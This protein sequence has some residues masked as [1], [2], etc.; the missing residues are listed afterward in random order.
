[1]GVTINF[2]GQLKS[3][4]DFST[5]ISIVT[6]F[7]EKNAMPFS[8]FEEPNKILH[9]VK[10]EEDWDY[11]GMTKGIRIQPSAN[12]EPMLL[13]FDKDNYI[14]EYCKTQFAD[15]NIHVMLIKYN[16]SYQINFILGGL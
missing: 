4:D 1:M 10:A 6:E 3:A 8:T 14:Q 5:V 2:E 9:R 13:E 15:I 7:A 12:S 16:S 11:E